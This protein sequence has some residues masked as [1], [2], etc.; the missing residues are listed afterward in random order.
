MRGGPGVGAAVGPER[1][2]SLCGA[3]GSPHVG[4]VVDAV[5]GKRLRADPAPALVETAPDDDLAACAPVLGP[6]VGRGD[7]GP[8]ALFDPEAAAVV[9][10]RRGGDQALPP[11][12]AR[13]VERV[14]LAHAAVGARQVVVAGD[15]ED[16]GASCG[17][18]IQVLDVA[19]ASLALEIA[20]QGV[21][22]ALRHGNRDRCA[23][24]R[25][26]RR[27][28]VFGLDVVDVRARIDVAVDVAVEGRAD[29]RAADVA[30]LVV[31]R[32]AFGAL[33]DGSQL[34]V[35]RPVHA[36]FA[37]L[38]EELAHAVVAGEKEEEAPLGMVVHLRIGHDA[39]VDAFECRDV[40][41]ID[42]PVA[43]ARAFVGA[44]GDENPDV[45]VP[46]DLDGR[47]VVGVGNPVDAFVVHDAGL[48]QQSG[49]VVVAADHTLQV[50]PARV[51]GAA[52][53]EIGPSDGR[54]VD[55]HRDMFH[56][57][58]AQSAGVFGSVFRSGLADREPDA[59]VTLHH[60]GL[61]RGVHPG[62]VGDR[63]R[64]AVKEVS[65]DFRRAVDAAVRDVA[66]RI[67]E[68]DGLL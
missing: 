9:A 26:P 32:F 8:D 16:H 24:G 29:L 67:V 44:P 55:G 10:V 1:V 64:R 50:F 66:A 60:G 57:V 52:V 49:L 14:P 54:G 3:E 28:P 36:V 39:F 12:P 62:V 46:V 6:C 18:E 65:G 7:D 19:V 56:R 25:G 59:A 22:I 68:R 61:F 48:L 20:H 43:D 58:G 27:A 40:V 2:E 63:C 37:G 51:R 42:A 38:P 4:V 53:D 11:L 21:R 47:V 33:L 30:D 45:A 41:G 23:A 15:A 31:S 5:R 34:P 35:G 17:V 13:P